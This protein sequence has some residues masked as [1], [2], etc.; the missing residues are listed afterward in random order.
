MATRSERRHTQDLQRQQ[1]LLARMDSGSATNFILVR[2][3]QTD[4]N[5]EMRL[6]GHQDPGLS[7][8]GV[9]QA[10]E[11]ALALREEPFDA[12]YSSDLRRALQTAKAIAAARPGG[13]Q[14]K[15]SARLREQRLGV[16]EGLTLREAA[17]QHP[18][19]LRLLRA[20]HDDTAVPGG[21]TTG[22]MRQR[23]VDEIDRIASTHPG[24]TVL[25]V[26]HGGVLHAVYNHIVGHSYG[27]AIANASLHRVRVQGR[28]WAVVDWN[29]MPGAK[30]AAA[31]AAG[32]SFGG[33][34]A[35][36]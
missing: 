4:W 7:A 6:Q 29:V 25:L 16:L 5:A 8:L 27:G 1:K 30:A 21:E 36:G 26:A 20:D 17:V 34:V 32:E 12:L 3:G 28:V 22:E 18:E 23:V 14:I 9:Q 35:E 10:E 11:L 24:Q 2:H 13:I 15:T 31:A 33:G 19:A